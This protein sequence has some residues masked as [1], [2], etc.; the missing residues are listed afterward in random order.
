MYSVNSIFQTKIEVKRSKFISF[1]LPYNQ[2][3]EYLAQLKEEHPKASHIIYAYRCLNEF[4][5]VIENSS[6][7]GEPKGAAATPTLNQM[8]GSELI[9]SAILTVRYFGGTKLGVGGMVRAYSSS[10]KAVIEAADILPFE[11]M[12][13]YSFNAPYNQQRQIEYHLKN[14]DIQTVRREFQT[15]NITWHIAA[16]S[17]KLSKLKQLLV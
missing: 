1:L 7:D 3:K 14:C 12:E 8:R 10:A 16:G 5:Q 15:D 4:S 17:S 9:E 13:E 6:D 2:F 11:P